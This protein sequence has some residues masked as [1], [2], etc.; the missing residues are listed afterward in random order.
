MTLVKTHYLTIEELERYTYITNRRDHS[1][2]S[3]IVDAQRESDELF[4][5]NDSLYAKLRYYDEEDS[6]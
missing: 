6:N 5:E 3:Q 4:W 1:L 2:V